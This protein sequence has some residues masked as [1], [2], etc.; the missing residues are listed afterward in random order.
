MTR[1]TNAIILSF[2]SLVGLGGMGHLYLGKWKE[3][4]ILFIAGI[5]GYLLLVFPIGFVTIITA[6]SLDL[7]LSGADYM[8]LH[9]IITG[10]IFF[11]INIT[12]IIYIL[13]DPPTT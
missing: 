1:K 12:H 2:L 10:L 5:A 6:A 9:Y 8:Y 11:T 13:K 7:D 3:S 4:I